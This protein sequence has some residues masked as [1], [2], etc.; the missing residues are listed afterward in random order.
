[1]FQEKYT[2]TSYPLADASDVGYVSMSVQILTDIT[3]FFHF[4]HTTI[5]DEA[6]R[7]GTGFCFHLRGSKAHSMVYPIDKAI[8]YSAQ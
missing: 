4:F 5:C 1:M 8:P 7:F 6:Q 2:K 3:L